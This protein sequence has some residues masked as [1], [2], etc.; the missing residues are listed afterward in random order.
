MRRSDMEVNPPKSKKQ[1]D[2]VLMHSNTITFV[3]NVLSNPDEAFEHVEIVLERQVNKEVAKGYQH[4]KIKLKAKEQ[5]SPEAQ[6]LLNLK[7]QSKESKKQSILEEI[8]RKALRKVKQIQIMK[9]VSEHEDESDKSDN[10]EESF[11]SDNDESD[12]D[13][14][15]D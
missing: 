9:T 14:D 13:F 10:D 4:L 5:P 1:K 3:D 6:L 12:K 11:E 2:A 7:I 15:D 8:Q